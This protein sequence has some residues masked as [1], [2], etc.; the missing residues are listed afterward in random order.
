VS[1]DLPEWVA[2]L[3]GFKEHMR[4]DERSY[5]TKAASAR[6][7]STRVVY[8]R[9]VRWLSEAS[10][11][12]PWDLESRE[13]LMWLDGQNWSRDTRRK[14]LVSVRAFYAWGVGAGHIEWAPTAGLPS[15]ARRTP[16]PQA[17]PWPE[18]WRAPVDNYVAALRAGSRSEGTI[19]QYLFRLRQLAELAADPWAITS[20]QL[21]QW[22]S[23]G[24]WSPQTKRCS[25]VAAGSF[26]RWAVKAGHIAESPT[27]DLETIRV[28]RGL[29]RPTTSD[30]VRIA[31]S[32]ADDRTR[33]AIML[34]VYAGLRRGEIAALH[35][36][37]ITETHLMV[38]GK[39]GHHRMVPLDPA[40][41]L[42]P[43]L[44][45]ELARRRRGTHGSGW[46]DRFVTETGYLFPSSEHPGPMTASHMGRL[47]ARAVPG[48]GT[49][50]PL[51]HRFATDANAVDRDLM[52]VQQLLGHARPETTSIYAQVPDGA[53]L[54]AVAGASPRRF[55]G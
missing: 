17:R 49:A 55:A 46:G 36:S 54:A 14:V 6:S 44:R 15:S 41:D 33:L 1:A 9:H 27:T 24:D 38:V 40:G 22:L 18:A 10:T 28:P 23:N 3:E 29:P 34:A 5:Q 43:E 42:L 20:Q 13:L 7:Y 16:G 50:H 39:G 30:A 26:Y 35:T 52:A 2:A 12:G 51:R 31:L 45:A 4:T 47:I 8:L 37:Q 32:Q 11:V 48:D 53:L 21:A 19:R 25:R